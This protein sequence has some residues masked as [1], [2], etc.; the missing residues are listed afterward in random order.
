MAVITTASHPKALWPG[1][2][3][4]WG[5]EYAKYEKLWPKVFDVQ[6]SDQAYEEDVETVG[7]G[8]MSV[9][10]QGGSV[11]YDTAQQG[12]VSRYTALTYAIGYMVTMEELQDNLY[13]KVSFKR[14]SR[15]AR[16]VWETEEVVHFNVFN[17]AFNS[18]FAGGDGKELCATD[19]PTASGNQ[20]NELA[21]A[22]DMSEAAI[23]DLC[24]QI[25]NATDSRGLRFMNKPKKLL[26]PTA[27]HFEAKRI[28]NST[29]QNDSANNAVNVL[30]SEGVF[31]EIITSPYLTD[32]DAWF[33]LTDCPDGLTHYTRMP[34]EF[35]KDN[36]FDT[37][38]LKA[39]AVMRYSQGW[40]NWRGIYGTPGA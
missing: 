26:V 16:S 12:Y 7:F 13:E 20:S 34:V 36:D 24:I 1:V 10:S 30:K 29:L 21:T 39:S 6:T 3:K 5:V 9:K 35:G 40:S 22:A 32:S 31:D 19:H 15:L 8:L 14:V 17:R 38:N 2:K 27:L 25:M 11:A 33:I 18:S 28:L 23:E 4:F 37:K